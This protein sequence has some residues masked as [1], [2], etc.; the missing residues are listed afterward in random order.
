MYYKKFSDKEMAQ[1]RQ[2]IHEYSENLAFLI[3]E[4]AEDIG[5]KKDLKIVEKIKKKLMHCYYLERK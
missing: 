1:I 5:S 3:E 4:D 2:A